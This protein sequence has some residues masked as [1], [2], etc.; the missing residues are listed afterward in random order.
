MNNHNAAKEIFLLAKEN[1]GRE[2]DVLKRSILPSS[3]YKYGRLNENTLECLKRKSIWLS[4]YK[5]LND[6]FESLMKYDLEKHL[7]EYFLDTDFEGDFYRNYKLFLSKQEIELIRN[8]PEPYNVY[9]DLCERKSLS[10]FKRPTKPQLYDAMVGIFEKYR[11][12]AYIG[13]FTETNESLL[14]WSHYADNGKG[15]CVDYCLTNID[16]SYLFP[17]YYSEEMYEFS[18]KDFHTLIRN[19][20]KAK[21]WEYEREWRIVYLTDK[22]RQN[23]HYVKIPVPTR[24]LL[25]PRF[26]ENSIALKD[27]LAQIVDDLKVPVFRTELSSKEYRIIVNNHPI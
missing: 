18:I 22:M 17:V 14:M 9:Y 2:V 26:D 16:I 1:K 19:I 6:P 8:S 23:N 7:I 25:G 10:S 15:I 5:D 27:A 12:Y 20:I 3:L 13:C 4:N 21:D 24:I 11:E